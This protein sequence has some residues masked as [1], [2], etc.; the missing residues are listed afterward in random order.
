M[1]VWCFCRVDT[2]GGD[3]AFVADLIEAISSTPLG[4]YTVNPEP[5]KPHNVALLG[6]LALTAGQAARPQLNLSGTVNFT[7]TTLPRHRS[8]PFEPATLGGTHVRSARGRRA[9]DP[10]TD[11]RIAPDDQPG[12]DFDASDD[13]GRDERTK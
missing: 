12:Q 13:E 8:R 11:E 7:T 3:G 5:G 2:S 9:A 1:L 10:D 6:S 4:R